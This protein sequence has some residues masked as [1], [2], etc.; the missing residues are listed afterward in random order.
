ME[1]LAG[2]TIDLLKETDLLK[3]ANTSK[4]QIAPW[5]DKELRAG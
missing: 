2:T 5:A 1:A 4:V 3:E